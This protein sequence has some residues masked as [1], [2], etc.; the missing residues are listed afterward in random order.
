[1]GSIDSLKSQT[2]DAYHW[3]NRI[4]HSIPEDRWEYTPDVL[5]TNVSWQTGH[6]IMSFYY[7]SIL[8]IAGHQT[9][10]LPSI[11]LNNYNTLFTDASPR[12]CLGKIKPEDLNHHL[13]LVQKKSIDIISALSPNDLEQPLEPTPFPH[14]IAKTKLEALDWNIKHAMYH[15]GQIGILKRIIHG[16]FDFGLKTKTGSSN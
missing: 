5:E 16:R 9:D 4:I 12:L 1:M 15:C 2:Q 6:L 7:H 11:P 10:L 3:I 14:P 8:V 13:T